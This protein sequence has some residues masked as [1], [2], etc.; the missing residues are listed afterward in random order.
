M[1]LRT[2]V[3]CGKDF[4]PSSRHR[5]CPVCRSSSLDRYDRCACGGRKQKTSK[6]CM[7]CTNKLNP[8]N[9]K[10][11]K[12]THTKGY[13]LT[14]D[15]A[16]Y[17]F[18]HRSVM[19]DVIGRKLLEDEFVHHKNGVKLDDR[20]DNLELWVKTPPQDMD[21]HA[22]LDWALEMVSRYANMFPE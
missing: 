8:R 7:S 1:G 15:G 9:W 13:N 4:A 11:G 10:G 2:C 18:N 14:Y 16:T 3:E 5:K 21:S 19:E 17:V 6:H 20:Q 22:S 12:A